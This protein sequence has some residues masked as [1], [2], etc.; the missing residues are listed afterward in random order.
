MNTPPSSAI[1]DRVLEHQL[2]PVRLFML[3]TDVQ[4][5]VS[6]RASFYTQPQFASGHDLLQYLTVL[7]LDKGTTQHDKFA[8]ADILENYGA[9]LSFSSKGL[10]VRCAGRALKEAVPEVLG[11]MAEQLRTPLFSTD[12]FEKARTHLRAALRRSLESTSAQASIALA[13]QLYPKNH[14]NYSAHPEEELTY[15][16]QLQ[17]ADVRN[18]HAQHFGA[19][20]MLLTLVGDVDFD[21]A[22][23]VVTR[24]L[25]NWPTLSLQP[26]Y[27]DLAETSLNPGRSNVH[28]ADK[29]NVDVYFGHTIPIKRTHPDFL[30]LYLGNYI[31]GGNFSA[32]LMQTIRD[33]M[34]LTYGIG[35][36]L[37]GIQSEHNGHWQIQVTLSH[38]DVERGIEAT[39]REIK[40]FVEQGV[41]QTELQEK[42]TTITGRYQVGL[43]TTGGLANAL[44]NNAERGYDVDYLDQYID[45]VNQLTLAQVNQN[46]E[47][48]LNEALLHMACAGLPPKSKI[49]EHP[50]GT[51]QGK[52]GT[53][54]DKSGP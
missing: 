43:A 47:K 8:I 4:D 54:P 29:A 23:E 41:V 46:I 26:T 53:R 5:V 18:Y 42:Q 1:S 40:R 51:Q 52:P 36:S 44:L 22:E 45:A 21:Q 9:Q 24:T 34:G 30:P 28:M 6:W 14:P 27:L 37:S 49:Y 31:L 11:L 33:E 20:Q 3:K 39:R 25:T 2:G 7:L 35:S 50:S 16:D 32:R 19:N 17:V 48:Y 13:R 15:L 38:D 10:R 12:E